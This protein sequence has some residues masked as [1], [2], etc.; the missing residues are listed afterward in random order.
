MRPHV[1]TLSAFCSGSHLF[2]SFHAGP[3]RGGTRSCQDKGEHYKGTLR[4]P[5]TTQLGGPHRVH[6]SYHPI[7]LRAVPQD[8]PKVPLHFSPRNSRNQKVKA[9]V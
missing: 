7:R 6:S 9:E 1:G 8:T 3:Q 5:P 2:L 4:G